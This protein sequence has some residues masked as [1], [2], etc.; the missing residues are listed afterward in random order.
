ML[1]GFEMGI[2]VGGGNTGEDTGAVGAMELETIWNVAEIVLPVL[3]MVAVTLCVPIKS[4]LHRKNIGPSFPHK[5][6]GALDSTL[7]CVTS[8]HPNITDDT[9]DP[10]VI[11][12]TPKFGVVPGGIV[13]IAPSIKRATTLLL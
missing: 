7:Y 12:F 11:A 13:I 10:E 2:N 4:R 1:G 3:D 5:A 9:G 6:Y 8:F